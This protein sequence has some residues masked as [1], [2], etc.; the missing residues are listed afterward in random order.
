MGEFCDISS[1]E[2]STDI[3]TTILEENQ[4]G[5]VDE[6]FVEVNRFYNETILGQLTQKLILCSSQT[7]YGNHFIQFLLNFC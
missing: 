4:T 1:S 2:N 7:D 5:N 6:N 3:I